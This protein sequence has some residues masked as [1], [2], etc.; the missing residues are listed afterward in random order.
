MLF[1]QLSGWVTSYD[2]ACSTLISLVPDCQGFWISALTDKRG[3]WWMLLWRVSTI[4][5]FF[6]FLRRV[7]WY[8]LVTFCNLF[9]IPSFLKSV[10][11]ECSLTTFWIARKLCQRGSLMVYHWSGLTFTFNFRSGCI[12][13]TELH[14]RRSFISVTPGTRCAYIGFCCGNTTR[15][16]KD[17]YQTL[18]QYSTH[19]Q[20]HQQYEGSF[21]LAS[22]PRRFRCR[23][24]IKF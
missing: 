9:R 4:F 18:L 5:F 7:Q 21:C 15:R 6:S 16:R 12:N 10:D 23:E 22:G 19:K 8:T 1:I 3:S 14:L 17:H 11:L 13:F 20:G 24:E 2:N